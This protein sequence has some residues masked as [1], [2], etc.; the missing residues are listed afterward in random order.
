MLWSPV[1]RS[2]RVTG[3]VT[4]EDG[5]RLAIDT[6]TSYHDQN[7]DVWFPPS[8]PF[9]WLHFTARDSRGENADLMLVEF[10]RSHARNYA[11][12]AGLTLFSAGTRKFWEPGQYHLTREGQGLIPVTRHSGPQAEQ[13]QVLTVDP[14]FKS[15]ERGVPRRYR[16]T[17]DDHQLTAELEVRAAVSTS[18]SK[19][20][21]RGEFVVEEQVL[22]GRASFLS[23]QGDLR[24]MAGPAEFMNTGTVGKAQE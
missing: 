2:G 1:L 15:G 16:I 23:A 7:W 10:P 4:L 13:F 21:T 8:Q 19:P 20:G 17:T 3:V 22:D 24:S 12:T 6:E 14:D 11:K 5:R 9:N 18:T